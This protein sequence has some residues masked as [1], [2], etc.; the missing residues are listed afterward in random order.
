MCSISD[1]LTEVNQQSLLDMPVAEAE[2][3]LATIPVGL[4]KLQVIRPRSVDALGQ[5]LADK[6]TQSVGRY[7]TAL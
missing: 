4:V 5:L 2:T 1:Q 7:L 6:D 3:I